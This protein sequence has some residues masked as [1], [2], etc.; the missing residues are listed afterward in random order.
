MSGRTVGSW[1]CSRCKVRVE[2][3]VIGKPKDKPRGGQRRPP[4]T[5]KGRQVSNPR[6]WMSRMLIHM[7]LRRATQNAVSPISF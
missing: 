1:G 7:I 4:G 2:M 5:P 3:N 6:R